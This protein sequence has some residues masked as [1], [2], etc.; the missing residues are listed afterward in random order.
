MKKY[1]IFAFLVLMLSGLASSV[2]AAAITLPNPLCMGAAGTPTGPGGAD[3]VDT[4]PKLIGKITTFILSIIGV[5]STLVFVIAGILFVISGGSPEKAGLAKKMALYAGIGI[6][7][8]VLGIGLADVIREVISEPS[9][10][11]P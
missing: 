4:F 8:A 6:V 9:T 7:V 11:A 1:L 3:C 2:F 10:P 5:L